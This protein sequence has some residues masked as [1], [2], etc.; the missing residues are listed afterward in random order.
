MEGASGFRF[1][2]RVEGLRVWEGRCFRAPSPSPSPREQRSH[3]IE[4]A[5]LEGGTGEG[6][7]VWNGRCFRGSI[8]APGGRVQD[9]GRRVLPGCGSDPGWEGL[10]VGTNGTSGCK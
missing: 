1:L 6:V 10:G 4:H 8:L 9:L 7:V 3:R 2:P 5:P